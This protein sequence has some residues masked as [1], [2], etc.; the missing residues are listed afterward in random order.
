ML[1]AASCCARSEN[2]A[3]NE[4]EKGCL[5]SSGPGAHF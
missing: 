2:I 4:I 3:A 5:C 1:N